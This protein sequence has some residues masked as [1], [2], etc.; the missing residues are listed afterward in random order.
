MRQNS[1]NSR[2]Q[3]K[4]EGGAEGRRDREHR[5]ENRRCRDQEAAQ[6]QRCAEAL[7]RRLRRCRVQAAPSLRGVDSGV[8]KS[9]SRQSRDN[10]AAK[11]KFTGRRPAPSPSRA[12]SR[13]PNPGGVES[14]RC[15]SGVVSGGAESR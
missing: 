14:R 10:A 15:L 5:V 8:T 11:S 3:S 12:E 9:E 13:V 2:I 7:Q 6:N 4:M 1:S